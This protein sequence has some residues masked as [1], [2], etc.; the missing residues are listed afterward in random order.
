MP[1]QPQINNPSK[2]LVT[3]LHEN[4]MGKELWSHAR[5]A[6]TNSHNGQLQFLQNEPSN[7][8]CVNLPYQAIGFIRVLN[9]K[10]VVFTTDNTNSE[11]GLFDE[12]NCIYEKLINDKAL[13]FSTSY[14]VMGASKENFDCS[15]SVYWTDAHNPRRYLNLSKLPLDKKGKLIASDLLIDHNIS[16][17]KISGTLT[18]S[19]NLKNG[20]YQFALAYTVNNTRITEFYSVSNPIFIWSHENQG[21]SI[22]LTIQN[23][24]SSYEGYELGVIYS[25]EDS[26]SYYSLGN[27][28]IAQTTVLVSSVQN[29][30][31]LTLPEIIVKR[32][33]Y[34]YADLVAANDHYLLWGGVKTNAQ[35][36]YQKDAMNIKSQYVTLKVPASYYKHGGNKVGYDRDEVYAFGIQ[37]LHA[38]GEW[39]P[40]Y[41]IPGRLPEDSELNAAAGKDAYEANLR[42]QLCDVPE[43]IPRWQVENTAKP[44]QATGN[45]MVCNEAISNV[46]T[47]AYWESTETYPEHK[48][49]FDVDSG[50]P[51]RH[52]KMPDNTQTHI[53]E[54]DGNYIN[55]LGVQFSNIAHP[56]D[57]NGKERD[58]IAGYRIVRGSRKG[59]RSVVAKGLVTN[60]RSYKEANNRE[61]LYNNYPF[62]DLREDSFISSEQTVMKS[63]ENY[64]NPLTDYKRDQFNLY[65][66]HALFRSVSLGDEVKFL[67]EEF[68]SVRG[69]FE[70]VYQHPKE[71]LL[72]DAAFYIAL[73]IGAID[74]YLATKGKKCI[75]KFN[76]GTL[77]VSVAGTSGA[78]TT[79]FTAIGLEQQQMCDDAVNG[80]IAA[81]NSGAIKNAP[82]RIALTALKILAGASLFTYFAATAAQKILDTLYGIMPWQ[83]YALQYNAIGRFTSFAPVKKDYRR[84]HLDY[85]QYLYEGLNTVQGTTFNN[86]KR[87]N[88]V[89]LKIHEPVNNP[90]KQDNTRQTLREFGNSDNIF[91]D[92]Q[93]TA[94]AFYVAIKRTIRNAYGTL[95][96]IEYLDTGY[97]QTNLVSSAG[98]GVKDRVYKTDAVFGGDTFINRMA[99]K[100]THH[101]FS[102]YLRD[103]QNGFIY[104]YR[105]F[106]N[107]GYPRYWMDSTPYD[108]SEVVAHQPSRGGTPKNKHNLDSFTQQGLF[109]VKNRYFYL[110]NSGVSEF[111]CESDFNLDYR[112]WKTDQPYFYSDY[113]SDLSK[114][115]RSDNI[116]KREDYVYDQSFSKEIVENIITAQDLTFDPT[117]EEKCHTYIKNR[118]IYSQAAHKEQKADHWLMYLANNFYDFSLFEFGNLTAMN[119]LDNQQLIFLFD[120][121]S[122]YVTVGR[123]LLKLDGSGRNITV[124]D[125]GMFAQEPRQMAYTDYYY[126]NSQSKWAFVSSHFGSIYPSQ[127]QGRIFN[128]GQGLSDI[129]AEGMAYWFKNNLPSHLL[130]LFPD[131]KDSDNPLAGVGL[132]SVFDNRN[133]VYYLTKKDYKLKDQ[134]LGQVTYHPDTNAFYGPTGSQ[135]WLSDSEYFEDASWTISYDAKQKTFISYHD[136][137]PDWLMQGESHFMS[138]KGTGI[139]K[140]NEAT[141]SFCNFYGV[142]YPFEIEYIINNQTQPAVLRSIEYYLEAGKYFNAGKDFHQIL[143]EN[144]DYMMVSNNEQHSGLLHLNLQS[145]KDL[146]QLFNFPRYNHSEERMEILFNKEENRYRVNQFEDLIRDRGEF[147]HNNYPMWITQANGYIRDINPIAIDYAKPVQHRK[148]F[149][150]PWHKVLFRK[151]ISGEKK[152]IFKY[153]INKEMPSQ[154]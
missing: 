11:I 134:W 42:D 115:F 27:H 102:Q 50:K 48:I 70:N 104:D 85:Y 57:A 55:I 24:D 66:P 80:A 117:I 103:V 131:F 141:D 90:R 132:N 21:R 43:V 93:S 92:T 83:Q 73:V 6:Q 140:H 145:K 151:N 105:S 46:G 98:V 101:F 78:G 154:R 10:W 2:G 114:L 12:V 116:E 138:V 109:E 119:A 82:E 14:P 112:D 51:I 149:R 75:T 76:N 53:Y 72:T 100:K 106:R 34:P 130:K 25:V 128:Y 121:A 33:R 18:S 143:D 95:D 146:S 17:P 36:D 60:V 120:K 61:V 97:L 77:N 65:A 86:Y 136:W 45:K 99:I 88:S 147:T 91:A 29:S 13:N 122:P 22:S 71:K 64:F 40:V 129:S 69:N 67:T 7:Y 9:F 37:W 56:K 118:V 20:A 1:E 96:S 79:T 74:G 152:L 59:H 148:K 52:H 87:E 68:A 15:E 62:N 144:F 19:G 23:L 44:P 31:V 110:F 49:L 5:N 32:P 124:G 8:L 108:I 35:I 39:S 47:M 3:D 150:A 28:G 126:G 137:H 89:Y 142:D 123:D 26:V 107:I 58:D 153:A 63:K 113:S 84:R 94:S 4:Y 139:W 81:L 16:V 135:I 30:T 41:H 133:E 127:R 54:K 111:F 125:G 38:N